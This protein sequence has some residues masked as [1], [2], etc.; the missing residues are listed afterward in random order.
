[1][2]GKP[3]LKVKTEYLNLSNAE[4]MGPRLKLRFRLVPGKAQDYYDNSILHFVS[5]T[6]EAKAGG[7][8]KN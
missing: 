5:Y 4:A 7:M 3:G 8:T 1:M 2:D 6:A